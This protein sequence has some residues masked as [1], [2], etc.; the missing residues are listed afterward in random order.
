MSL[1]GWANMW[2][3]L[4]PLRVPCQTLRFTCSHLV[5]V[6]ESRWSAWARLPSTA[7]NRHLW[8][9]TFTRAHGRRVY[10]WKN[11]PTSCGTRPTPLTLSMYTTGWW[12]LWELH[13]SGATRPLC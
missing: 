12:P 7:W 13:S 8:K 3:S 4:F 9:G 2:L 6:E 10:G 1:A 11:M 5:C